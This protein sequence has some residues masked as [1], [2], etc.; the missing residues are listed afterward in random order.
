MSQTLPNKLLVFL[1]LLLCAPLYLMLRFFYGAA[2]F[3]M[4]VLATV[5]NVF[6]IAILQG[7]VADDAE[8]S[9]ALSIYDPG[10]AIALGILAIY[11]LPIH[12]G[13]WLFMKAAGDRRY[14]VD[15]P[16][17]PLV[18]FV[19]PWLI[20]IPVAI[21]LPFLVASLGAA[22]FVV[23]LRF[24]Q[25]L[26]LDIS[27]L[28]VNPTWFQTSLIVSGAYLVAALSTAAAPKFSLTR[29]RLN[30]SSKSNLRFDDA[31]VAVKPFGGWAR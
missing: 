25:W 29:W 28:H 13:W 1:A 9:A 8:M 30:R 7:F 18:P 27:M 22:G 16:G 2:F 26:G 14:N 24:P 21:T 10:Y 12:L 19:H 4:V 17:R 5:L 6:G 23:P 20:D 3:K 11:A 31:R 15:A